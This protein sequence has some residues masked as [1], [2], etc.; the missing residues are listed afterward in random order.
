MLGLGRPE[1][2][3]PGPGAGPGA[4]TARGAPLYPK[5]AACAS[6]A[7]A[8]VS[9]WPLLCLLLATRAP[10]GLAR[11][12]RSIPATTSCVTSCRLD[13]QA[14]LALRSWPPKMLR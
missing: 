9:P 2:L 1:I 4:R 14:V 3:A 7:A 12:H 5:A 11:G 8:A 10:Q 13:R 6:R